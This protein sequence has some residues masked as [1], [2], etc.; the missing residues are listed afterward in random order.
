VNLLTCPP[1]R[2]LSTDETANRRFCQIISQPANMHLY[3]LPMTG[4]LS[5]PLTPQDIR[6]ASF[7]WGNESFPSPSQSSFACRITPLL[8]STTH[9]P[10]SEYGNVPTFRPTNHRK[11]HCFFL[12]LIPECLFALRPFT[13]PFHGTTHKPINLLIS[14]FLPPQAYN[15]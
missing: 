13:Y 12:S 10:T 15:K 2:E 7:F 3:R 6:F 4:V 14:Y 9:L 8:M 11:L 5:N 1:Y